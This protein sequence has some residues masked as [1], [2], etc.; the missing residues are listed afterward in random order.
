MGQHLVYPVVLDAIVFEGF[1]PKEQNVSTALYVNRNSGH[2]PKCCM[3]VVLKI[4]CEQALSGSCG[5]GKERKG[6]EG[7]G[8]IF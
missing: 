4:A 7:M 8:S 1:L 3:P 5:G 6:P 2:I